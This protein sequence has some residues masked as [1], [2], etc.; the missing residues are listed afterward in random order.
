MALF[1]RP[2]LDRI[3]GWLHEDSGQPEPHVHD[4]PLPGPGHAP[5]HRH[6]GPPPEMPEPH[7]PS[8]NAHLAHQP[9][10]PSHGRTD[11]LRRSERK[12]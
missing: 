4:E 8:P 2:G 1:F 7:T 9:W 6:L 3:R 10:I 5:G 11:R 12:G